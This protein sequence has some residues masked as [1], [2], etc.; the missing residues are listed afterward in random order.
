MRQKLLL[1]LISVSSS[2][3][4]FSVFKFYPYVCNDLK[5]NYNLRQPLNYHMSKFH[6]IIALL[7]FVSTFASG[8]NCQGG[9]FDLRR[10]KEPKTWEELTDKIL[11]GQTNDS[12]RVIAIY[13]WITEN[14]SYDYKSYMSGEPIRFQSP[15]RVYE[16][17]STTCTGYSNLM[18]SMLKRAG[19]PA[20]DVEGFTHDFTLGLDSTKLSSDHAWVAFKANGKW[21]LADP[22]WDAGEIGIYLFTFE[23]KVKNSIMLRLKRFKFKYLFQKGKQN[24]KFKKVKRYVYKEGFLRNPSSNY[25]FIPAEQFLKTHLPNVAHFQLMKDPVSVE[26]FCDSIHSLGDHVYPNNG[27]FDFSPL[28]DAFEQL[29]RPDKLLW[30]SDS[31]LQYHHL[32]HGDKAINAH[33]YLASFYGDR[34]STIGTL[35]KFVSLS[36]TVIVHSQA[37]IKLN[38]KTLAIKRKNFSEAF[39]QE[40]KELSIQTLQQSRIKSHLSRTPE[41]YRKGRDRIQQKEK[42]TLRNME[43]R[44]YQHV[45]RVNRVSSIQF[46]DSLKERTFSRIKAYNDSVQLLQRNEL[47]KGEQ[48]V[49]LVISGIENSYKLIE[50]H[51]ENLYQGEFL[52]QWEVRHS[53]AQLSSELS[54][55][56]LLIKDSLNS[57][58]SP[59]SS[60]QMLLKF[61]QEI[62]KQQVLWKEWE[63]KDSTFSAESTSAYA[64]G[65]LMDGMDQ[66]IRIID[67]RLVYA[68]EMESRIKNDFTPAMKNLAENYK[69]MN[70]LRTLRQAYLNKMLNNKYNRSIKVYQSI[71]TNAKNWKKNYQT[72]L[73]MLRK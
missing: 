33:N 8:A 29:D 23:K 2:Y 39:Q 54:K 1:I 18:V 19:I 43:G 3:L 44:I 28:N 32:N 12:A 15:Q 48:Y 56:S 46:N 64:Y 26:E 69:F 35:E 47:M 61:D 11:S 49:S 16:R 50:A 57:I 4:L 71:S 65:L 5:H 17:R 25:I 20:T 36:D 59:R 27:A 21:Y 42:V 30:L 6:R 52:N 62:K 40:R 63:K 10:N 58:L 72:R 41:I 24:P 70:R 73:K 45:S 22:T 34:S 53:D 38:R 37:G 7:A 66:E 14:I 51:Q 67:Q 55:L 68:F 31:S 60:L 13:K 9:L